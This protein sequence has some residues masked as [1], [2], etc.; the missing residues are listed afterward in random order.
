M[1]FD[2]NE[3]YINLVKYIAQIKGMFLNKYIKST[4]TFRPSF[5]EMESVKAFC[6]LS[7]ASFEEFF[8]NISED[9]LSDRYNKYKYKTFLNVDDIKD[10]NKAN[11]KVNEIINTYILMSTI[12]LFESANLQSLKKFKAKIESMNIKDELTIAKISEY[13]ISI[14]SYV[15]EI[16]KESKEHH[17]N[18]IVE[19]HGASLKY[20]LK[21]LT[22]VGIDIPNNLNYHNSLAKIANSRGEYAHKVRSIK[23]IISPP[24]ARDYVLDCLKLCREITETIIE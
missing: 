17:K 20:L 8:E 13:I 3:H 6:I 19:N 22:P 14:N 7:H 11:I 18:K 9:V 12:A 24:D 16:L 4:P 10:L 5:N 15:K 23:K 1:N 21:I 2:L